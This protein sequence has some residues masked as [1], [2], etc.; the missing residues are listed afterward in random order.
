MP[1]DDCPEGIEM[2]ADINPD[3][4]Q[5]GEFF[6]DTFVDLMKPRIF[7]WYLHV[8]VAFPLES[9]QT[10]LDSARSA[11]IEDAKQ[12]AQETIDDLDSLQDFFLSEIEAVKRLI[13]F[14]G[15]DVKVEVR[16]GDSPAASRVNRNV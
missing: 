5:F 7:D 10:V 1:C 3:D 9:G 4:P 6:K 13:E 15:Y 14:D 11:S 2:P 16:A 8:E 12:E